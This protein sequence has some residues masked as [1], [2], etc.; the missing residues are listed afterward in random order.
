MSLES[1]EI[2]V[3]V[4]RLGHKIQGEPCCPEDSLGRALGS[5]MELIGSNLEVEE[6]ERA[7]V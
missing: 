6:L 5:V 1:L 3:N 7:R 2:I 4:I